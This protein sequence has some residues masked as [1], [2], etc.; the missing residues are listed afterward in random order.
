MNDLRNLLK[1][2]V[3]YIM[4]GRPAIAWVVSVIMVLTFD[5]MWCG[6]TTFRAMSFVP[7]YLFALLAATLVSAPAAMA[8]R[9]PWLQLGLWLI[10]AGVMAA[11]IMYF[12]TYFSAIPAS[13]YL[14]AGNL[15]D[16]RSSVADSF[17]ATDLLPAI[18]AVAGYVA[19][20]RL[21]AGRRVVAQWS[22][23]VGVTCFLAW[24]SSLPYGGVTEHVHALK[25]ECYY[26]NCP[27]AIYTLAGPLAV[28]LTTR[29]KAVTPRELNDVAEW[30]A[31]HD[32]RYP[33]PDPDSLMPRRRSLVIVFL[34]SLETWPIG[35]EIEGQ[36]VTPFLDSLISAPTTTY[37]P[38]LVTQ[39]G[40]GRSIDAQLL[41]LAGMLPMEG[42]V[43]AMSRPDNT[44]HTL[45]KAMKAAGARRTYLL[46]GDKAGVW[47]QARFARSFGID[48]LLDAGNWTMTEKI[49]NPPK[50][51][52]GALF[53][54]TAEKMK[55]GEIFPE[56]ESAYVHIVGYSGHNPWMI[57]RERQSLHLD[58]TYPP[59]FADY[60]TAVNYVDGALRPLIGYLISRSDSDDMM[61][62][63]TG[64]HEG[65]A[66]YRKAMCADA[67]TASIVDRTEHTPL[68]IL[69]S[70]A[71]GVYGQ[72][73]GQ[74]DVYTTLVNLMGLRD[75]PWRGMGVSVTDPTH[76]GS[77]VG[78]DGTGSRDHHFIDARRISDIII[79]HNLLDEAD[80][81]AE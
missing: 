76:P 57:P 31:E 42:D 50:L 9:R 53:S 38:N 47:N 43:A 44:Y 75:Y 5:V 81:M 78:R 46:T 18:E 23:A 79:R 64:D 59:K 19:M 40:A 14:M 4:T 16:F 25:Q 69:N 30:R 20:R 41:M 8:P 29:T 55:A 67:A 48:S 72:E 7:T 60:L 33:A 36:K 63:I 32:K 39:V 28:E 51:A 13:G 62:A 74:V 3:G 45:P 35:L 11:N 21:P 27:P 70:P 65:L 10:V 12:R 71:P 17:S 68:I 6:V 26:A 37:V 49:G 1:Q 80:K 56:G 73:A 15:I 54:Q 52:D 2:N 77:A 22:A 66:S 61:I 58:G 24:V 34:E